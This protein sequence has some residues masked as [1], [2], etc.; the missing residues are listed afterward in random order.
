VGVVVDFAAAVSLLEW[1]FVLHNSIIADT[2]QLFYCWLGAG[3][4]NAD[5]SGLWSALLQSAKILR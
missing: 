1:L 5:S 2:M 4:D 3:G